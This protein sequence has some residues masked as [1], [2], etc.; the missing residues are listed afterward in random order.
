[1]NFQKEYNNIQKPK[2]IPNVSVDDKRWFDKDSIR[3]EKH[4][5]KLEEKF[6]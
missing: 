3:N 4:K 2:S 1:M 6:F 5:K